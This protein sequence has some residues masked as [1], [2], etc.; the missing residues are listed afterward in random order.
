MILKQ[1]L[2]LMQRMS[3]NLLDIMR[4]TFDE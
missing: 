4:E 2:I 3:F 1:V